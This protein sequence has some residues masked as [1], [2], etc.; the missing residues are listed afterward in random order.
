MNIEQAA[1]Q[2]IL[3]Q[4]V[5]SRAGQTLLLSITVAG[6]E[7]DEGLTYDQVIEFIDDQKLA[8]MSIRHH[9][10]EMRHA[11]LFRGCLTRLGLEYAELPEELRIVQ[12]IRN[13]SGAYFNGV[14]TP[15]NM[16]DICAMTYVIEQRGI[17][18]YTA[19]ANAFDLVDK[20]TAETYR[21]VIREEEY[22]LH[23][24]TTIGQHYAGGEDGWKQA[25]EKAFA[26][27]TKAMLGFGAACMNYL[28]A[29]KAALDSGSLQ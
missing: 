27:E 6:E 22:H 11:A 4:L 7:A 17:Q 19:W 5:Q 20:E 18:H 13:I 2:A 10:D 23:V 1:Q 28:V 14:H 26:L 29:Q 21:A 24:C 3:N 15:Q 12:R 8:Q 16:V 9:E 25:L